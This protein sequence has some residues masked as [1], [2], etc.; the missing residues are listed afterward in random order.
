MLSTLWWL[1]ALV[2]PQVRKSS[3][4]RAVAKQGGTVELLLVI[5]IA[6]VVA[7]I[8]TGRRVVVQ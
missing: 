2:L 7:L 3:L 1:E 8:V 6:F 4:W 5:L